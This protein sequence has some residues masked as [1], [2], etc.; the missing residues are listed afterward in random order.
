MKPLAPA[1]VS[2]SRGS[3]LDSKRK[4]SP[5]MSASKSM[6]GQNT[7]A[8]LRDENLT[9]A[10]REQLAVAK[11]NERL[12]KK[13][14]VELEEEQ[15]AFLE[16]KKE[17]ESIAKKEK[18]LELSRSRSRDRS[19]TKPNALNQPTKVEIKNYK[20]SSPK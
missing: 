10:E 18:I 9:V 4:I 8:L 6:F 3:L 12:A 2:T 19:A 17:Q 14:I 5:T 7:M 15:R 11:R 1:L 20:P 16:E 13:R